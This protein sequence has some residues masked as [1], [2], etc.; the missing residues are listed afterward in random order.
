MTPVDRASGKRL[1][2]CVFF[3]RDGIINVSPGPGYVERW[4]DFEWMPGIGPVLQ[5]VSS[6][7]FASAIISN[8]RCV[9]RGIVTAETVDGIH[10]NL[11]EEAESRWGVI[12]LDV[13]YCPHGDGE[14]TCRKPQPGMILK[15]AEEHDLDLSG[16][17]MVGDQERDIEA[18][19]RAGCRTILVN[20]DEKRRTSADYHVADLCRLQRTLVSL[21]AASGDALA[22]GNGNVGVK[23]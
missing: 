2:R 19:R 12:F 16:S 15:A 14:C 6:A 18:G 22:S 3:D 11:R 20:G 17:W 10:R 8:Q 23:S 4:E 9:S 5:T 13:L 1:K 21:L 7:G